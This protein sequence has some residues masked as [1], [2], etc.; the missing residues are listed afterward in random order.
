M[1]DVVVVGAGVIGLTSALRLQ[2]AGARVAVISDAKPEQ[3]VSWVAAAVWYPTR[4]DGDD[5]V[6]RW[7]SR[8]FDELSGQAARGVPGVTMRT[9]KM[10]L[11]GSTET[12]WWAASVP[13]FRL[14]AARGGRASP[15]TGEWHFT[16]PAVE[17]APYLHWLIQQFTTAG[18][19]LLQQHISS[20][21][22][23]PRVIGFPNTPPPVVAA[24][25]PEASALPDAPIVINAT[26]LAAGKLVGDAAVHPIRGRIVVVS[27]PG[28]T[29]S[30]RDEEDPAGGTYVHPR[31]ADIVLG[32]TFEP[33]QSDVTPDD[34]VSRSL[35]ERATLLVPE[36]AGAQVIRQMAGLRP[37]RD[38]GPRVEV[39]SFGLPAG[40]LIHNYGH[41]GAGVT[42]SWGCADEIAALAGL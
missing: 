16:V 32:G 17:M 35:I 3:T 11:R 18:G 8:T 13:D 28:W 40:Q 33:H 41:A 23:R 38:G 14:V 34:D 2:Q 26:G 12:P 24:A 21:T 42:L 1:F 29:I 6:L 9:T 4:T 25:L 31:S 22:S 27:N 30:I 37:G 20:L 10:L 19:V 7:A 39:D 15:Y 5:R 36:L